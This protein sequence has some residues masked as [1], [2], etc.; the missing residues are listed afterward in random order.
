M[1]VVCD[2]VEAK[3]MEQQVAPTAKRR[4]IAMSFRVDPVRYRRR[5]QDD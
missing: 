2:A 5:R 4:S 1:T 3:A